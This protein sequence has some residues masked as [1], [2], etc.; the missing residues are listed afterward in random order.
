VI[1]LVG[2]KCLRSNG[3]M[4][5]ICERFGGSWGGVERVRGGGQQLG[6]SGG[7]MRYEW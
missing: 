7:I 5:P 4:E 3:E 1:Y 2:C 6:L